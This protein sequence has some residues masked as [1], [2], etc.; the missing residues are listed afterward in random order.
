MILNMDLNGVES[1]ESFGS[2]PAGEYT[3]HIVNSVECASKN[4]DNYGV[5]FTWQ[6]M[7]G[8]YRGR[9]VF[10]HVWLGGSDKCKEM[11]ARR[12]KAIAVAGSHR[13]P[14]YIQ[15]STELH[16]LA[17][18]IKVATREWNG[19][20]Q[21][22]V[23]AVSAVKAASGQT[24]APQADPVRNTPP[25]PP[26]KRAVIDAPA[27]VSPA[28]EQWTAEDYAQNDDGNEDMPF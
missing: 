21:N 20:L 19:D 22:E 10:D 16:G 2:I 12:L 9:M 26:P 23:K 13:N 27:S 7:D 15:D 6:I 5:S 17:C 25:P 11:G 24:R 28:Q 14:N 3:A 4:T 8:Q 1:S 18:L